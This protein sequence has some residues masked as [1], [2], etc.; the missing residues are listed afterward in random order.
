MAVQYQNI[1]EALAKGI[2]MEHMLPE[3]KKEMEQAN[4]YL[5][6]G[7]GMCPEWLE[8]FFE[9]NRCKL[10][11]TICRAISRTDGISSL[12]GYSEG[13]FNEIIQNANDLYFGQAIDIS[14]KKQGKICT[15]SCQYADLGFALSNIYGFLNRE[16]SD[17]TSKNGQTGKYGIGIKAFFK[18]VD[19]L[20]LDSNIKLAFNIQRKQNDVQVL[21]TVGF[22]SEWDRQ[23]TT[24]SF[25]YDS[26]QSGE[27]NTKKLTSFIEYLSGNDRADVKRFFVTGEDKELIF[28]LRSFIFMKINGWEIG[29]SSISRLSF[30]GE[31]H[32]VVISCENAGD[33]E[34]VKVDDETW[35]VF[36]LRL[37]ISVDGEIDYKQEYIVFDNSGIAFAFPD[38]SLLEERNRIYATYYLKTDIQ[39]QVRPLSM[40]VNSKYSNIHRNDIGDSEESIQ[41]VYDIIRKKMQTLYICMCSAEMAASKCRNKVSDVFHSIL[42]RYM[43]ADSSKY[44][45]SPLNCYD[46]NNCFLPK[47]IQVDKKYIVVHQPK[48][49]YEIATYLEGDIV[50]ELKESYFDIVERKNVLDYQNMV[51]SQDCIYG[52]K[53]LY[54]LVHDKFHETESL[55]RENIQK[56]VEI[57]NYFDQVQAFLAFM[58]CGE[59]KSTVTDAEID[60]WLIALETEIGKYF[61]PTMFLKL[62]G[63]YKINAAVDFDGTVRSSNL[64]FKDYLFNQVFEEKKG[65]LSEFQNRQFDKTYAGLKKELLSKRYMDLG[66]KKDPYA[67]RCMNPTGYSLNNWNGTFDYYECSGYQVNHEPLSEPELF[68]EKLAT[69]NSFDGM[70]YNNSLRLFEKKAGGMWRRDYSFKY[71]ITIEQ[72]IIDI[73]C[74]R[75]IR[76]SN[77]SK[78]IAAIKYRKNLCPDLA[79]QIHLTCTQKEITTQNIAEY[80]L[81]LIIETQ[82]E[83]KNAY[84]LDEFEPD[85]VEIGAIIENTNNEAQKENREFISKITGYSIHLYRFESNTR[86]KIVAYSGGGRIAIRTDASKSFRGVANYTSVEKDVYIFYDNF[87]NDSHDAIALALNEVGIPKKTLELLQGYIHNGNN[88]KTMNYLS[89]RR[90][91]AK[92]KR[93][94]VLDWCDIKSDEV[95]T[96]YDNEILYRLFTAR[97]SYDIYCPICSD[98]PPETFDYGEDIKR[99][100]SRKIIIL[101]NDSPAT[102]KEVPYII[103][104]ACSYCVEKLKNTLS[105]SEFDGKNLTLTTQITHGQYEKMRSKRQIELS[106]I[107]VELMKKFKM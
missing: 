72:Q 90:S 79:E 10:V 9:S 66:N 84:L 105:K 60:R 31:C 75:Q 43:Y 98:I 70:I 35:H 107:N 99:K 88:T 73:S 53:R 13:Y 3:I 104:V 45:E 16:M 77:F 1:N 103:T 39:E 30:T 21:G 33:P 29:K 71:F 82:E 83:E 56:I 36:D 63:R 18:F 94:L 96:I 4:Q 22:N 20:A 95:S 42:I 106:P 67:I 86:R 97:G 37:L 26:D 15:L 65:I 91:I 54:E 89:R 57:V 61:Q 76:S 100:H 59:R 17:K 12:R 50:E 28:D 5:F 81:P 69:D 55:L 2:P 32:K 34:V 58:I 44:V 78:F 92:V 101:E 25:A 11:E 74:I 85:D 48:E 27:F 68:L 102:K 19:S 49:R 40:L 7:E 87:G 52:V 24:L 6:A 41:H 80:L 93:K 51:D 64:S 47:Q 14:V 23:T 38:N 8:G 46:L 62:V